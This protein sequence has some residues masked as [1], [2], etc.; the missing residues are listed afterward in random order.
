MSTPTLITDMGSE[1]F[2]PFPLHLNFRIYAIAGGIAAAGILYFDF[3]TFHCVHRPSMRH[4]LRVCGAKFCG[5]F[6]IRF[7]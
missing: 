4:Y 2:E 7:L 6:Y 5:Q 1:Y 3:F